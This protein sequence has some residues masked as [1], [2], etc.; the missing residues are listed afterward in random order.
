MPSLSPITNSGCGE[1][2]YSRTTAISSSPPTPPPQWLRAH[3]RLGFSAEP[4]RTADPGR[5]NA[6]SAVRDLAGGDGALIAPRDGGHQAG[7]STVGA[8]AGAAGAGGAAV[9]ED[10]ARA[11]RAAV[12][13]ATASTSCD[14]NGARNTPASVT[15]AVM[16]SFGVMSK[17]G[18]MAGVSAGAIGTPRMAVTSDPS[19]SSIL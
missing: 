1:T 17:A 19:R 3:S 13:A 2:R 5:G 4:L 14:P 11:A 15:I 8:G 16:R 6:R 12:A 7:T 18:L 10:A 9:A